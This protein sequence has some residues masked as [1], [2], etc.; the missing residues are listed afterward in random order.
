MTKAL[1]RNTV[2][3][4][5]AVVVVGIAGAATATA[6]AYAFTTPKMQS[7]EYSDDTVIAGKNLRLTSRFAHLAVSMSPDSEVHLRAAGF[8][9]GDI[10]TV[11]IA[12]DGS[13]ISVECSY[14]ENGSCDIGVEVEIPAGLMLD[15]DGSAGDVV[16][17]DV[18]ARTSVTT[19]AGSVIARGS[20]GTLDVDTR[21]GDVDITD[22]DLSAAE[23]NTTFG[24]VVLDSRL[25]PDSVRVQNSMGDSRIELP[26]AEFYDVEAR[27]E[28]GEVEIDVVDD[29][30]S[31][32][33]V[34]INS[35]EGQISVG[36]R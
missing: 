7:F 14:R 17:S 8:Y 28:K 2:A 34:T 24:Q 1:W 16:L 36:R 33:S 13:T 5:V 12:D 32:R 15:I 35:E 6:I 25:P 3:I 30:S 31:P 26:A 9:R 29:P 21:F 4:L 20:I 10:P 22:A 23:V 27:S 11:D 18:D 19:S